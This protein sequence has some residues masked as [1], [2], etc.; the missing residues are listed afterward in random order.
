MKNTTR[1]TFLKSTA[2]SALAINFAP[3]RVFGANDR[4]RI[5]VAGIN[6]RGGSHIGAYLGMKNVEVSH[7]IDPDSRL[8]NS[9]GNTVA[10]R[11]GGKQPKMVQDI[12]VALEDK[13][14]DASPPPPS[15]QAARSHRP[16]PCTAN[17]LDLAAVSSPAPAPIRQRVGIAPPVY[18][19]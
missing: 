9:R 3:S 1:R 12:R 8:F 13:D 17:A 18:R 19:W 7:L 6:G 4:V 11:Q 16:Q 14:L 2:A 5:G 10:R 15:P